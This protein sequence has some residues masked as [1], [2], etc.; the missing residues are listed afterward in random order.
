MASGKARLSGTENGPSDEQK[1]GVTEQ[2]VGKCRVDAPPNFFVLLSW[3]SGVY[4]VCLEANPHSTESS[5]WRSLVGSM[6]ILLDMVFDSDRA[7][8]FS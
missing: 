4:T 1:L 3:C 2:I 6:T 8:A 7:K 5:S